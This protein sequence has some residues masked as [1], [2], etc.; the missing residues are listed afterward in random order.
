MF[1]RSSDSKQYIIM[2]TQMN[3]Q[4]VTK[5]THMVCKLIRYAYHE[6]ENNGSYSREGIYMCT[7]GTI[8]LDLIE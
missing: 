5:E 7:V 2:P 1:L 6:R 4:N 3:E 8:H